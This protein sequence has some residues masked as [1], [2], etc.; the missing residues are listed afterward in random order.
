MTRKAVY[1]A[2]LAALLVGGC[3]GKN[4]LRWVAETIMPVSLGTRV[5]QLESEDADVRREA[6][7]AIASS[8]K[9]ESAPALVRLLCVVAR[10]DPD[11]MVRAGAA[12]A[13]GRVEGEG[14]VDTL[15]EVLRADPSAYVRSDAAMALGR[16][17][18]PEGLPALVEAMRNDA[19]TDVRVAAGGALRHFKDR[20]AAEALVAGLEDSNVAQA[21]KCWESLRYVTG[22]DLPREPAPW[23]A[24]FA[25]AEDPFA[26]HG[27]PPRAPKGKNQRPVMTKTVGQF[28][29]NLFAED[30]QK[31]ELE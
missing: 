23:E 16:K 17:G 24:F 4:P 13:L 27:R 31:A 1:I 14:V 28:F 26:R 7:L 25:S 9:V 29:K 5:I 30:V 11:A 8:N 18:A 19:N 2:A 6:V 22:Q 15:V 20:A 12:R 21:H 3:A 10:T